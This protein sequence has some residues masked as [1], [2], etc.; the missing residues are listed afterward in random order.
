MNSVEM[1]GVIDK[2]EGENRLKLKSGFLASE[3]GGFSVPVK[4]GDEVKFQY[5]TKEKLGRVYNNIVNGSLEIL[6]S[7][8]KDITPQ[9]EK[10]NGSEWRTPKQIIRSEC[11][12]CAVEMVCGAEA[13]KTGVNVL[14]L[15]GNFEKWVT[16]E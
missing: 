15:A 10:K 14:D 3:Y 13:Y 1:I 5:T 12:K 9:Y 11:L 8:P 7:A 6:K 2:I 4:Y 16:G